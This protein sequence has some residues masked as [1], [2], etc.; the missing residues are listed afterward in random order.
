MIKLMH[1]NEALNMIYGMLGFIGMI[2]GKRENSPLFF[3]EAVL[4]TSE[5]VSMKSWSNGFEN[6][7]VEW[8]F[9]FPVLFPFGRT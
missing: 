3:G 4:Y 2:I 9:P 8:C 6:N 5:N 7:M 1:R